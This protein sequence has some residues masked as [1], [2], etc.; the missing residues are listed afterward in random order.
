MQKLILVALAAS[1]AATPAF[2]QDGSFN[3]PRAEV[4]A[5]WDHADV[6]GGEMR[7]G[8]TYGGAIGYDV[9]RG[10][11][12][13]GVE[14]EITGSTIKDESQPAANTTFKGTLGRDLYVGGRIGFT[15]TP[16]VLLYAKAGYTN[17]RSN[18]EYRSPTFN[19]DAGATDGGYR[20]GAGAEVKLSGKTYLKGEYRYS[21]YG[22]G[23]R[24]QVVGGL[25]IRF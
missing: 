14:G 3:G 8:L 19:Q 20:L 24:H 6:P 10:S 12:V 5:G 13:F 4:I 21:D 25:G 9:Q 11:T 15:A 2:A 18:I 7:N 16:N 1:A 23:Q 22:D 17:Q